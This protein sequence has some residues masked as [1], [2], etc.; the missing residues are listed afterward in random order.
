MNPVRLPNFL[1]HVLLSVA[2][3]GATLFARPVLAGVIGTEALAA[4]AKAADAR[5]QLQTL[6]KR[7]ELAKELQL[8]GIAPQ[9]AAGRVAAMN[10][11]EVLSLSG[12][13]GALPAGGAM[14]NTELLIVILL[15]ILVAL[16]L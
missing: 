14:T 11:A 15:I 16:V 5:A 2:L 6:V 1:F 13:L 8:L 3:A 9:E 12:K 4:S 10:D 7:P